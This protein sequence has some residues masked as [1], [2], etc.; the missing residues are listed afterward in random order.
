M[1]SL[2]FK[3]TSRDGCGGHQGQGMMAD[4]LTLFAG[5]KALEIIRGEGLQP[6]RISAVA[7]AAGGP[8]WLVLSRLDRAL[9]GS[10]FPGPENAPLSCGLFHRGLALCRPGSARPPGRP[11]PAGEGLYRSVLPPKTVS[12]PGEPRKPPYHGPIP[13]PG[14]REGPSFPSCLPAE[15]GHGPKP[16]A[17]GE[18]TPLPWPWACRGCR[19]QSF[20]TKGARPVL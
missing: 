13:V 4:H 12:I 3:G 7:S 14:R 20:F 6:E 17:H 11:G 5:K 19:G 2:W 1:S 15:R 18:P 9:F 10:F 16:R 8:K